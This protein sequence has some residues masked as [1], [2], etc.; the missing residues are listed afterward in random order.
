MI[1]FRQVSYSYPG[2]EKPALKD[3]NLD[4]QLG[5]FNLVIGVSGSGKSTLLRC[6]NGLV[7]HF[8]GGVLSGNIRVVGL[9]PVQATPKVM[10]QHVGFI[11][12]DPEYQFILDRVEDEL[13]FTLENIA[14]PPEKMH[15]RV[16]YL[17]ELLEIEPLRNRRINSLSG[18]ERQRVAIGTALSLK[19]EILVLDEPTSQLDPQSAWQVLKAIKELNQKTGLTILIAEHRIERL[20]QFTD[21]LIYINQHGDQLITGSARQV[22]EQIELVPP[23]T[24]LAKALQIKPLPVTLEEARNSFSGFQLKASTPAY[25]S[26]KVGPDRYKLITI[27]DLQVSLGKSPVLK[28]LNLDIF[29]GE[30]LVLMGA[31]GSG[32]TTL[33]RSIVGL[34]PPDKGRI[35]IKGKDASKM[36][37]SEICRQ[38]GYLP[39]DPNTLL[40]AD[41]VEEELMVTLRNHQESGDPENPEKTQRSIQKALSQLGLENLSDQYPRDLSVG[42]RQRT[43][44]G[45]VTITRPEVVLL[46]E[47]TRGLDYTAKE[48]LVALLQEWRSD[49]TAVLLVT[50]DVELAARVADRAAI[51]EGGMITECGSPTVV[52]RSSDLFATQI[53]RLFPDTGWLIPEDVIP[54]LGGSDQ[55][56]NTMVP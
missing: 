3:I 17:L 12:Q 42:Q 26:E 22:L 51:L 56:G 54:G 15:T 21:N 6:V 34:I 43:A 53:A 32:K 49:G 14:M 18:G 33:L 4:I 20:L 25:P 27:T 36:K 24:A 29:Q 10:C 55:G 28:H 35:I 31:N 7:P 16:E 39:Q 45:A 38:I 30:I 11:F 1:T 40:F 9:D 46:D 48:T 8:S 2:T 44:L 50:H 37:V 13:A 52:M 19:P 23:V 47:P 41:S 5:T